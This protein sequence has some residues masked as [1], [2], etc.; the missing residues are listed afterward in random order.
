VSRETKRRE[1]SLSGTIGHTHVLDGEVVSCK[2]FTLGKLLHVF[3]GHPQT[4][5]PESVQNPP[6]AP[7][8]L[9]QEVA[10]GDTTRARL[11]AEVPFASPGSEDFDF[12]ALSFFG[13]VPSGDECEGRRP[14]IFQG[15]SKGLIPVGLTPSL[16]PFDISRPLRAFVMANAAVNPGIG[17]WPG[18]SMKSWLPECDG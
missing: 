11:A 15:P 16:P 6:R 3:A 4:S 12:L 1:D 13:V 9:L 10:A 14:G 17:G 2:Q 8:S 7:T 18:A 5:R